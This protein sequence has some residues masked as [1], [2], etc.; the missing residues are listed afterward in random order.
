[1]GAAPTG[2]PAYHLSRESARH[3]LTARAAMLPTRE[4]AAEQFAQFYN[5]GE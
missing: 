3:A 2:W 1:M 4:Q 5:T